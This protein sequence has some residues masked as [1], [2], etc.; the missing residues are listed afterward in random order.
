MWK[1]I[2]FTLAAFSLVRTTQLNAQACLFA[3]DFADE[4]AWEYFY[5][6]YPVT[7]A[8]TSNNQTGDLTIS[9]GTLNYET[10][11]DANDTRFYHELGE[12][13][14]E[15]FWTA[16]MTF[17]PTQGGAS[18]RTG[19]LILS[20]TEGTTNPYSD[21]YSICEFSNTDAIMLGW[22]SEFAAAPENIGFVLYANDNGVVTTSEVLSAPYNDTYYIQLIRVA[23][24]YM[25]L[26]VYEDEEHEIM[27][28][29][30]DCFI[31]P[32]TIDGL[33]TVQIGNLPGGSYQRKLTATIDDLCVRNL[34]VVA[35]SIDGPTTICIGS[36]NDYTMNTLPAATI[37][38]DVPAGVVYTGDDLATMTV[39]EWPGAGTYTIACMISY[40]CYY[41]TAYLDVTVIDPGTTQIIEEG[42][43]EGEN[44]TISVLQDSATYL[45]Y[46]GA[47]TAEHLFEDAGTYWV[48]ISV[49][50]CFYTD[51]IIITEYALPTLDLGSDI[52]FCGPTT[53]TA[54]DGFNL[55]EWSN[56]INTPSFTTTVTGDYTLTV[57]DFNGCT[58]SDEIT[59]IDG[60][61]DHIDFPT[62]F[63]PNNDN[64]N[65]VFGPIYSGAI[66]NYHI[67]IYNR[68]GQLVFDTN[69]LEKNWD[70]T[71]ENEIQ[72]MGV[73]TYFVT[74][75]LNE[76]SL[77]KQGNFT[78]VR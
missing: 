24:N 50:E 34:D 57:T 12:D 5:W 78:L 6:Y 68:W 28:G 29:Q 21:T 62:A 13:L 51:S 40:N 20:L 38:W 33:N 71:F 75:S 3:D 10:V 23:Y 55:Y 11:I 45:W 8:C 15:D 32:S 30:I 63:S 61:G 72:E 64:V 74:A 60:C 25:H 39:T 46:D 47:T 69:K 67:E 18:G 52:T 19:D 58:T 37:D 53:V 22:T 27:Y 14:N 70:G 73:Y 41:D 16:S 9:G 2:L 56:G 66:E 1:P 35:A 48:T 36:E 54:P 43:C 4:T 7:G 31:V 26:D 59:L 76:K 42:F 77:S 17:T 44:T 65:D 49:G